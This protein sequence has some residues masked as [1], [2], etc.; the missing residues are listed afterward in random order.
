MYVGRVELLH[1][2]CRAS[3]SRVVGLSLTT[4]L[5]VL[6]LMSDRDICIVLASGT[7]AGSSPSAC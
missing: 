7:E 5:E 4:S 2:V 1:R 3:T 6:F